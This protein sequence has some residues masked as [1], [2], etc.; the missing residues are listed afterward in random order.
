MDRQKWFRTVRAGVLFVAALLVCASGIAEYRMKA[1]QTAQTAGGMTG[2][3]AANITGGAADSITGGAADSI[4]GDEAGGMADSK[5]IALTF[6]DG[7]HPYCTEQLLDGLK[8]RDVKATFFVLGKH[9]E[10]YPELVKR[11]SREGHLVGNHTYSHIQL[12]QSN[13][14]KFKE[15]LIKTNELLKQLTGQEIQYVRP[16]YGTW[17]KKFE[18]ELNM[19]PV[20]W[21]IDP[22]DWSSRNVAGIVKKVEDKAKENAIIL[23]HDEYDTTVTAALQIVDELKA[24]GYEFV[25]VDELLFD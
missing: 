14:E 23:M 18:K 10:L 7:P 12:N 9:A 24:Q 22:L 15:E 11:M 25:T 21:T 3:A 20:L 6:D 2:G 8:E 16:P 17:D 5:R 19:F 13:R 1:V 4:T